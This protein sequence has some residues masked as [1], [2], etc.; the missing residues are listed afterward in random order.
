MNELTFV[1]AEGDRLICADQSGDEFAVAIGPELRAVVSGFGRPDP[2]ETPLQIPEILRP[3]DIQT[4][5]RAGAV[6]AEL[7]LASGLE[8][9]HINRYAA[10][11][12]D[13]REYVSRQARRLS[14]RHD[15]GQRSIEELALDR[16]ASQGV[17]P[18]VLVWDAVREP[19][20]WVVRLDFETESGPV[21]ARWQVD[22][23]SRSLAA[24]N[25]QAR[26]IGRGD[27]PDRPVP[28]LRH[29]SAVPGG[30]DDAPGP[31]IDSGL[32]SGLDTA[33]RNVDST[34]APLSLLDGL[35]NHRGLH[36]PVGFA[37][38][39]QPPA[40]RADVLE[41][42]HPDEPPTDA[43]PEEP[44]GPAGDEFDRKSGGFSG[45]DDD[46]PS[47]EGT[48]FEQAPVE[49]RPYVEPFL[50]VGPEVVPASDLEPE[51]EPERPPT[52][53]SRSQ[54]KR[55]SVPSWDEIVFG[56]SRT[57]QD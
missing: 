4:L 35:M 51:P 55:S 14:L 10:P 33:S 37:D 41:L 16:V 32:D 34:G 44:P 13:E 40:G 7:A 46:A 28:P 42:R 38:D 54:A 49:S 48:L 30:A 17:D 24:L 22:L 27:E 50:P 15:A 45:F 23:P 18:A 5:V 52:R 2:P 21:R 29:L 25:D 11:V 12:L 8:L 57:D 26:W 47:S 36:Q 3:K 6:P 9:E 19:H 1:R 43:W 31:G 56:S 53:S 20:G 39:T